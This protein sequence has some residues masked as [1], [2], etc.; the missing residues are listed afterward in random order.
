MKLKF[1]SLLVFAAVLFACSSEETAVEIQQNN[2]EIK[3]SNEP[4]NP[5]YGGGGREECP[6]D[7][8]FTPDIKTP[9]PFQRVIQVV[10]DSSYTLEEIECVRYYYFKCVPSMPLSLHMIQT[11]DPYDEA[12][13]VDR[14]KPEADVLNELCND[15]LVQSAQCDD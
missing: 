8:N 3:D 12:W 7:P 14:G 5:M 4:F 6:C 15:P 11:P 9:T 10:Y 13:V 1:F 2:L